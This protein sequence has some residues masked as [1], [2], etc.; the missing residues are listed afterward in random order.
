[1]RYQR[2]LILVLIGWY[3]VLAL[4]HYFNQR[5]LW[6]DEQRVLSN[7]LLLKHG[8]LFT[9]PLLGYQAFPRLYLWVIQQFSTPFHQNLLALRLF[10]L[11]A[12][13]GAFFVWLNIARKVLGHSWD[14]ILFVAC[15]C[16]TMPLVYYAAELK[17]YSMD[18]LISGVIVLFLLDQDQIQKN[19]KVYRITLLFLPLLGL[20]SYSAIFL[21]LLPLY[22]LIRDCME[23][24]RWLPELSFYLGGYVLML[25]L[26]YLFD[27]RASA[28]H[29]MEL[30]WHDYFISLDSFKSFLNS[31]GKGMN[32]L[33]SR[34]F[35]ESPRWVKGPSR[36]FIGLGVGY[37][38]MAF[39]DQFK[40]D[41]F[42]LRSVIPVSFIMLLI[43]LVL[44]MLRVYPFSVPRMSL[45]FSPL[46]FL[47]TIMAL[48]YIYR[49]HK[50]V[51]VTLQIIFA[52]YLVFVSLG[53]AL[54]CVF[55]KKSRRRVDSLQP[56]A[57]EIS[58]VIT[59][60][61]HAPQLYVSSLGCLSKINC[62]I[63]RIWYNPFILPF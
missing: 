22:N 9:Q 13:M 8:S 28:P 29:L 61:D 59:P 16:A 17:P 33:V 1:M 43:Q 46:L 56:F 52:G 40:K 32:N 25:G 36:V 18:V 11:M 14:L 38:L 58:P 34:R 49:Q 10:S 15:W 24:R 48:G 51:G 4:G 19:L 45:F 42:V 12:M 54:G 26:V 62:N 53:I 39:W 30:F 47:M 3:L 31:F 55:K 63:I 60:V 27:Y 7:I 37:M 2:V 6:N 57:S 20:W 50:A 5:P 21:L 35:A 41:R 44:A 23:Q